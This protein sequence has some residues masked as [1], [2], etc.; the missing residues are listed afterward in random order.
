MGLSK[1]IVSGLAEMLQEDSF[2]FVHQGIAGDMHYGKAAHDGPESVRVLG[3]EYHGIA[4]YLRRVVGRVG[5]H[6]MARCAPD[7]SARETARKEL[8]RQ[9]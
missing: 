3:T 1:S 9:K 8:S 7:Y 4:Y 5:L 2:H 6:L